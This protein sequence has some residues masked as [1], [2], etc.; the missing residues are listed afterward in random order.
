MSPRP[1]NSRPDWI[2]MAIP[3]MIAPWMMMGA[4]TT[5]ST[6]R[7]M[8]RVSLSPETRAASTYSSE[9][10]AVTEAYTRR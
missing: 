1:R 6:W 7:P 2:A 4:R 3:A 5:D 8:M 10:T 9:R